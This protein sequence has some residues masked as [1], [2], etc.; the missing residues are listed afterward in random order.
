MTVPDFIK[1]YNADT[2]KPK[3]EVS[4]LDIQAVNCNLYACDEQEDCLRYDGCDE[5]DFQYIGCGQFGCTT[6]LRCSGTLG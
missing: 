6:T 2:S 1:P 3:R 4:A 5:C